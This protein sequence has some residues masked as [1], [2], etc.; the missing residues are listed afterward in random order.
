MENSFRKYVKQKLPGNIINLEDK[1]QSGIP[2]IL[3]LAPNN[4]VHWIE[5]KSCH[6]PIRFNTKTNFGLR[7][8]QAIFLANWQLSTNPKHLSKQTRHTTTHLLIKCYKEYILFSD[9]NWHTIKQGITQKDARHLAKLIT[10]NFKDVVNCLTK[11]SH[12]YQQ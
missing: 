7:P 4:T 12:S 1:F 8:E 2:D 3:W 10:N 9:T 6:W 5:L 11:I